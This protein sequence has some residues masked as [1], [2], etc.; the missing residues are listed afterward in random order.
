MTKLVVGK[1]ENNIGNLF[2]GREIY[3]TAKQYFQ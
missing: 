1:I 2:Y 3:E